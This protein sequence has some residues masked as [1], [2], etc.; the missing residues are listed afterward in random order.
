MPN[1]PKLTRKLLCLK[2]EPS[3]LVEFQAG[4]HPVEN[5]EHFGCPLIPTNSCFFAQ[6]LVH[7]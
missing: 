5:L 4:V 7:N 6:A 3:S 1:S 2:L